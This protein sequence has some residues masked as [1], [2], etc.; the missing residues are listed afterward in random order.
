[1][2]DAILS[3]CPSPCCLAHGI[4]GASSEGLEIALIFTLP[5]ETL[6]VMVA[7]KN[8]CGC[9]TAGTVKS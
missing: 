1:M 4:C 9:K 8:N 7:F 6:A 5:Q 2:C 3:L